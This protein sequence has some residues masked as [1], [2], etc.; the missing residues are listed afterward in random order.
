MIDTR[1][2]YEENMG[3]NIDEQRR[4]P[5][6]ED[7]TTNENEGTTEREIEKSIIGLMSTHFSQKYPLST[8]TRTHKYFIDGFVVV[9]YRKNE[10][11]NQITNQL[12]VCLLCLQTLLECMRTKHT[13]QEILVTKRNFIDVAGDWSE[14]SLFS[15]SCH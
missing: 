11:T 8:R 6:Q 5:S 4:R 12:T 14:S 3:T 13:I 7:K 1:R 10:R 2:S 15:C 9:V